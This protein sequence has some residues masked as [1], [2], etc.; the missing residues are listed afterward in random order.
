[1]AK[2]LKHRS[3]W[4]P[5]PSPLSHFT[6]EENFAYRLNQE[7]RAMFFAGA[8]WGAN[9]PAAP[10]QFIGRAISL[11]EYGQTPDLMSM[12]C[13]DAVADRTAQLDG[14]FGLS[15][16]TIVKYFAKKRPRG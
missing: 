7:L 4:N 3:A 10:N 14:S 6:A 11:A 15:D 12:A 13:D 16:E 2:A 5:V 8:R 1:M 9:N